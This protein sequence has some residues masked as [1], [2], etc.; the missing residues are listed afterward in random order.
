M[1]VP[2]HLALLQGRETVGVTASEGKPKQMDNKMVQ[3]TGLAAKQPGSEF[4]LCQLVP[5][6]QE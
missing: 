5:G 3:S 6:G 4:W 1:V 2:A